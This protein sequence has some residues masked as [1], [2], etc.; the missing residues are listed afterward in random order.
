[1]TLQDAIDFA[2]YAIRTTI[3]TIRFQHKEKTVGGPIDILIVKP[4][5]SPTWIKR[6]KLHCD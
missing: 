1:M 5:E 2:D 4:N 6:K 3:E